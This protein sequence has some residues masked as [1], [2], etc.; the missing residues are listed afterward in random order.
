MR[1]TLALICSIALAGDE[2]K[3][4]PELPAAVRPV[5]ELARS[6]AP[7]FFAD[8]IVRM[9]EAGKIPPRELQV[10]L[11]EQAFNAAA[12]AQQPVRLAGIPGIPPDTRAIYQSKAGDLRLDALSLQMRIF[13]AMLTVD[14]AKARELFERVSHP[15]LE[16][17]PCEDPLI[18]D[19]SAYYEMAG[20]LT[21]SAFTAAE[22]EKEVHV[23]FLATVLAG[24]RSPN[25]LAPFARAL[26]SVELKREQWELL[27]AALAGKLETMGADYRPFAMSIDSLQSELLNLTGLARA[28][29]VGVEPLLQAF[30]KYL[31]TQLTAPRC[32]PDLGTPGRN[33]EWFWNAVPP[34]DEEQMKPSAYKGGFQ[35][36]NYFAS[37]DS[38]RLGQALIALRLSPGGGTRSEV[39]RSTGEW[40]NML[41]DL[42][43]DF[44]GWRSSGSDVD[45]FHQKA[46]VLRALFQ[47]TPPGEDRDRVVNLCVAFLQSSDTERQS[48]AEWL[49]QVRILV[50]DSGAD[51]PKLMQGFRASGDVGLALFAALS[52]R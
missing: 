40:R 14:R 1:L 48:P 20:A 39:D 26:Q 52:G 6:A 21:Q 30:R 44:V 42:L 36:Q 27:L 15:A 19:V 38:K 49:W 41:A 12:G 29:G 33:I 22:K 3:P 11:L 5:V 7:E 16:P 18:A 25:E 34:L 23:Q 28:N 50:E 32:Q 31:V 43:R 45:V 35:A 9:M 10:E 4:R 37:D 13:R 17:R 46:T 24:A 8:A 2:P 51:A 47:T